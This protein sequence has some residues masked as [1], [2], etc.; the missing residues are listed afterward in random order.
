[1]RERSPVE[2]EAWLAS[3]SVA[4]PGGESF[5][6]VAARSRRAVSTVLARHPQATVVVI[7]HVSPIKLILRDA[8]VAD[9]AFLYRLYLDPGGVSIMDTWPDGGVAVRA[10]NE[11]GHLPPAP[12]E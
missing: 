8:L 7:S 10:V 3:T 12:S 6:D 2:Q 11:T 4:P 5:E 1:V 9:D